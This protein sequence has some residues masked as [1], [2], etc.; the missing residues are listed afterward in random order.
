[1]YLRTTQRRNR[2]GSVVRYVQ[3]AHNRRVDGV[4]Q[5][6]VLV[7]FGREEGVDR[8]GLRRLVASVNRY[9]GEDDG[10]DAA[11]SVGVEPG[12]A[13]EGLRLT[14]SRTCGSVWL[15]DGL[16][17]ALGVDRALG[18]VLGA[19]RF[20]TDLE[21][22]LFALVAN[23]ATDP[24]SKLAAIEWAA[25]DA[26]VPGLEAV[27][28]NHPYRAMDLLV[29]ADTGARVQEAVFFSVADLLTLEVDVLFFDTTSTYFERDTEDEEAP[30]DEAATAEGAAGGEPNGVVD[31]LRRYGHSKDHRPDLPQVVIGLAVTKEGIPVRVW[32]W[33]GNTSDATVIPQVKDDLCGWRLG[34][35]VTV[36][37]R[38]FSSD[39]NLK[40]LSRAGGAWIAGE[41][42]RDGSADTAAVLSRQ[43]RYQAV[44]DN[45][46]VK[47]VTLQATPGVRWIIC[48][49]PGEAERDKTQRE[50]ALERVRAELDRI[51]VARATTMAALATA[52]R[53]AKAAD[54]TAPA[55]TAA[56]RKV[57]ALTGELA[58]HSRAEC[59]LRD[60]PGL[61]RWV[62]QRPNGRLV[63]D[64]A[65]VKAEA[66]L[67]GKYLLSTN[68]PHLSSEDVALGYKNLLEAERG[69]RDM[70][71]TLNLRPVF[72]RLPDRIRAHVLLA[73]LALLL[74]RVA[75]RRT[76]Q[77][78]RTINRELS[79]LHAVT[80]TG[81]AGSLIQTTE[82]TDVQMGILRACGL[83]PPPKVTALTPA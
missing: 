9:L 38:G 54:A 37:D 74:I 1:M 18:E 55:R 56:Q 70:K 81:P 47:E 67:D 45:L 10:S 23:R 21:R 31:G 49:N 7:N 71:S 53:T 34:R 33:P 6:Q 76:G 19:R 17:K 46:R 59:A 24:A 52:K 32:C 63:I 20:T 78:W 40:Y 27:D 30:A 43:G 26:F 72:H 39:D 58:A 22:V 61:G 8:D 29:E 12:A 75:E 13:A 50:Q 35:V 69:F 16:W 25:M 83:T 57:K 41:R 42:M 3:L 62:K 5:A 48:H 64:T 68:D 28:E 51:T 15:L 73:W 14:G 79:R 4:T 66:N 60:H 2:D 82:P 44:R 80:L 11:E 65:K 77:T 36:V